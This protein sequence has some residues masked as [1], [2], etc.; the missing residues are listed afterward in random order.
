MLSDEE[1]REQ[2]RERGLAR[3]AGFTWE[4]C[5]EGVLAVYELALGG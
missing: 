2:L 1:L 4:K 3:A 5:A